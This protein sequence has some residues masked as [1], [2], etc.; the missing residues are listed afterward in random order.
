MPL[1]KDEI[2]QALSEVLDPE[3]PVLNVVEMGIVREISI[4]GQHVR[5]R[6]TPTYSGCPAMKVIEQSIESKLKAKGVPTYAIEL[7]YSPAWTTDWLT[8]EAKAKLKAYRI[9]P[10]H[11]TSATSTTEPWK[12]Q[13]L[14]N[15]KIRVPCPYCDSFQTKI[16]SEFGSTACKALYY[17][18]NCTQ[19]FEH[20]KAI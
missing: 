16:K 3:I 17:C 20:F 7:V 2:L 5:V 8:D 9:A 14:V 4:E 11:L 15:I 12:A 18:E 1:S 6:I 13:D 10:P 19:P